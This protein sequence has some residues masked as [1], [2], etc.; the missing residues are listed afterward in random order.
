MEPS[1]FLDQLLSRRVLVTFA[2]DAA[3]K[4]CLVGGSPG[5][6]RHRTP[7]EVTAFHESG[8]AVLALIVGFTVYGAS[9][10]PREDVTEEGAVSLTN[11]RV[12][13]G[14]QSSPSAGPPRIVRDSTDAIR[15]CADL[16]GKREWPAVLRLART[17]RK[18][19]EELVA[20]HWRAITAV[21]NRLLQSREL[22][23]AEIAEFREKLKCEVESAET[24]DIAT[25]DDAIP[26]LTPHPF[27]AR[28]SFILRRAPEG[29]Q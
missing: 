23:Q 4:R 8:H 6:R 15:L 1:E 24:R 9:I 27:L 16:M 5:W 2:G 26:A 7:V 28:A 18:R 10:V 11:G 29:A 14:L 17:L 21:A 25:S 12:Q 3:A 20:D 13:Y 22:N 19:S